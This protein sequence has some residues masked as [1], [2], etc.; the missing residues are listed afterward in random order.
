MWSRR[1]R[2]RIFDSATVRILPGR[3]ASTAQSAMTAIRNA[4]VKYFIG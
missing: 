2:I 3:T 4:I 1:R